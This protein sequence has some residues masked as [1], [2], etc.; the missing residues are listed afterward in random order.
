MNFEKGLTLPGINH[1]INSRTQGD[2][3]RTARRAKMSFTVLPARRFTSSTRALEAWCNGESFLGE[4]QKWVNKT[5]LTQ[6]ELGHGG[7]LFVK[8]SSRHAFHICDPLG[9][10]YIQLWD[11]TKRFNYSR[12]ELDRLHYEA[13]IKENERIAF[14]ESLENA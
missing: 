13:L 12:E 1:R 14:L 9:D 11:G 10:P 6:D 7:K 2:A 3:P 8:L 4:N 5:S